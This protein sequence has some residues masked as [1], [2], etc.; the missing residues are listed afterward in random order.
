MN[1]SLLLRRGLIQLRMGVRN[2]ATVFTFVLFTAVLGIAQSTGSLQGTVTDASGAVLASANVS[3]ANSGTGQKITLKTN[4]NGIYT[5]AL[6]QPGGYSVE[7][8]APGLQ[9]T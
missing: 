3:I 4:D 8:S 5:A 2:G 1:C 6:L 9:T 7:V